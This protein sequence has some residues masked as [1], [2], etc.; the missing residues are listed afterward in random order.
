MRLQPVSTL[1]IKD[2]TC[3]Y[4]ISDDPKDGEEVYPEDC[5]TAREDK[6]S[7]WEVYN[8]RGC[9]DGAVTAFPPP[10]PQCVKS[11]GLLGTQ[12][13][14]SGQSITSP[15]D[16]KLSLKQMENGNVVLIEDGD[17]IWN[18]D[19]SMGQSNYWTVLQVCMPDST[20]YQYLC[21]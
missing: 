8:P 12:S 21:T 7:L 19:S 5:Y 15:D 4:A 10:P 6:T 9:S 1:K 2:L 20:Y 3:V 11:L 13:I 16:D 17:V 18:S 14:S